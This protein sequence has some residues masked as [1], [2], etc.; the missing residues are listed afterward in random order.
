MPSD[1]KTVKGY[2]HVRLV[3]K[4]GE[5]VTDL[6]TPPFET[7]PEIVLWGHRAFLRCTNPGKIVYREASSYA[8]PFEEG[9]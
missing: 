6:A 1:A 9:S 3:T 4:D 5:M 8:A 2:H 7:L